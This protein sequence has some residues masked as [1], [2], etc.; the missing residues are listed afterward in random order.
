MFTLNEAIV[1]YR[2]LPLKSLR[3]RQR[4]CEEQTVR[5][6]EKGNDKALADLHRMT[7]ALQVVIMERL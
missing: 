6:F 3:K 1:Y 7:T 4:M 2:T 5:A